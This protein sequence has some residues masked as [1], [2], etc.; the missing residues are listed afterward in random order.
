MSRRIDTIER[1]DWFR[2]LADMR[3]YNIPVQVVADHLR[4][5]CGTVRGWQGGAEPK[6]ADGERLV[7]LWML[8]LG[9]GRDKLPTTK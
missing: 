3:H 7:A 2:V 5:P 6:H 1:I 8:V 9:K 4:I